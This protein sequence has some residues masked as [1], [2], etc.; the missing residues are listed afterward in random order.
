MNE[1]TMVEVTLRS[2]ADDMGTRFTVTA[3]KRTAED[4]SAKVNEI[5]A[6]YVTAA[7]EAQA[8]MSIADFAF[9]LLSVNASGNDDA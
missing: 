7:T 6:L 1:A 8:D 5:L 9:L 3:V 2:N 4:L